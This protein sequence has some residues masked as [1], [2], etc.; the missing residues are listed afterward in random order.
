MLGLAAG[1]GELRLDPRVPEEIGR[2]CVRRLHAFGAE[3]EVEA[4]G[5]DGEV[6]RLEAETA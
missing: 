4:A 2:I 5:T 3:W 6:R 1:D